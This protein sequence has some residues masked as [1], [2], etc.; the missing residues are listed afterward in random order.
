[1]R[2]SFDPAIVAH[3][4]LPRGAYPLPKAQSPE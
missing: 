4:V 2:E 3:V 1:M